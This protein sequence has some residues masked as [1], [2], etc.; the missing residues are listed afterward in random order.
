MAFTVELQ[1]GLK[2]FATFFRS[3]AVILGSN[4][5]DS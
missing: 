1:L 4:V 2:L 3:A 5:L